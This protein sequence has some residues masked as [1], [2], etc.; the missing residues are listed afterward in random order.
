[1]GVQAY[2]VGGGINSFSGG[3]AN[4]KISPILHLNCMILLFLKKV[5]SISL[6]QFFWKSF[7]RFLKKTV[8]A[9][10]ENPKSSKEVEKPEGIGEQGG[11]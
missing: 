1:M 9:L 2:R 10:I 7:K 4:F 3:V 11:G 5:D 8:I 6:G